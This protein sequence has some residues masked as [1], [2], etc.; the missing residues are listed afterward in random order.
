MVSYI[1]DKRPTIAS[2]LTHPWLQET[3]A[4]PE[5]VIEELSKRDQKKKQG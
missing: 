5:E 2:L 1:P 3:V 4:T